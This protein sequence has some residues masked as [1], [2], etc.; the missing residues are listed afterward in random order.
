V[1][2]PTSEVI[3]PRADTP[4]P[5]ISHPVPRRDVHLSPP[6]VSTT[7]PT[8]IPYVNEI[9]T[10]VPNEPIPDHICI[11]CTPP[12]GHNN[13]SDKENVPPNDNAEGRA[14]MPKPDTGESSASQK[15]TPGE[16]RRRDM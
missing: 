12:P 2:I 5:E 14:S 13:D 9:V 11:G 4:F 15:H 8:H 16:N 10:T 3:I 7:R 6:Y 1:I